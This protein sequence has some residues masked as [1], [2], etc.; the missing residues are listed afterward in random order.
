MLINSFGRAV[1]GLS[2]VWIIAITVLNHGNQ[3][4]K[5]HF[6]KLSAMAVHEKTSGSIAD[7]G[8][9]VV[10]VSSPKRYF[11]CCYRYRTGCYMIFSE[12]GRF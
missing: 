12:S 11:G 8:M 9:G 1:T 6:K 2:T 7:T 10:V 5:D 3:I 4:A